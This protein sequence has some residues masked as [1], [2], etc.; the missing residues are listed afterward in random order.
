MNYFRQFCVVYRLKKSGCYVVKNDLNIFFCNGVFLLSDLIDTI[1][2]FYKSV[3]N[4][5]TLVDQI[6]LNEFIK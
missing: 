5:P 4:Q 3:T 6:I 2:V 1:S